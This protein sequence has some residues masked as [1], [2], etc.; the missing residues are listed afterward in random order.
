[1]TS[2]D[3]DPH[4]DALIGSIFKAVAD[5]GRLSPERQDAILATDDDI[6]VGLAMA[7]FQRRVAH[8]RRAGAVRAAPP[9]ADAT[10]IQADDPARACWSPAAALD[11]AT[12]LMGLAGPVRI[13]GDVSDPT[14]SA[15]AALLHR[16]G[17]PDTGDTA[18]VDLAIAQPA[19]A[20]PAPLEVLLA[21]RR[22]DQGPTHIL[23]AVRPDDAATAVLVLPDDTALTV[24]SRTALASTGLELPDDAAPLSGVEPVRFQLAVATV[25]PR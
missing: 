7:V 5:Y 8:G 12:R 1:M 10:V 9:A 20:D 24:W 23:L 21:D 22:C 11:L 3:A 25:A 6:V 16:V 19:T 2:D 13:S 18:F 15:L 4:L 17:D 14:A